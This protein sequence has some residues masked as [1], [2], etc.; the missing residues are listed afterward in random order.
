MSE[1][2]FT[3]RGRAVPQGSKKAFVNKHT[4]RAVITEQHGTRHKDWRRN[5]TLMAQN[6]P[7]RPEQPLE[8]PVAVYVDLRFSRPKNHYHH[9]KSGSVLRD[10]APEY[11]A[12]KAVGDIDKLER[13]IYDALTDAGW[14]R[15]DSQIASNRTIKRWTEGA[16]EVDVTVVTLLGGAEVAA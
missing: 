5:V 4:G 9:R 12:T 15:D 14:V 13:A 6:A 10:D 8:G 3:I 11:V 16:D 7:T 2:T 1:H